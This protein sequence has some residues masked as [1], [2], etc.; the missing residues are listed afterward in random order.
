MRLFFIHVLGVR[1]DCLQNRRRTKAAP[2][3]EWCTDGVAA[4]SCAP[5]ILGPVLAFRGEIEAQGR[6]SLHPH[7]LVW[8]VCMSSRHLLDLL[9]RDPTQLKLRLAQWMKACVC[10]MESTCQASV[11]SMNR[12][13]GR[14]G[15]DV[16]ALPFSKTER[17]LTRFDG[18]SELNTLREEA[19]T[20][21]LSAAQQNF[22]DEESDENWKRPRLDLR[23][24]SGE[25]LQ[26][27]APTQPRTSVF[28]VHRECI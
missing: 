4:S 9:R 14:S 10:S 21:E 15:P 2:P 7:I 28:R 26:D 22:L 6:G 27:T 12:R 3:R 13:F 17:A 1:P 19:A 11:T 18:E 5:G 8:L 20:A 16:A 25:V 23:D 24:S